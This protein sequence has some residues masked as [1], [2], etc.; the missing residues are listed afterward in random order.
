MIVLL[1]LRICLKH[2]THLITVESIYTISL[3]PSSVDFIVQLQATFVQIIVSDVQPE[4]ILCNHCFWLIF[5]DLYLSVDVIQIN[6]M[7]RWGH[8]LLSFAIMHQGY[9]GH[10]LYTSSVPNYKSFWLF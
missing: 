7:V 5:W 8:H 6:V 4:D 2:F 3:S 10:F 9:V 1:S